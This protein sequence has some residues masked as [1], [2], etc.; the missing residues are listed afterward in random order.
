L[1]QARRID[2]G[3]IKVGNQLDC[4][5]LK[6]GKVS[7]IETAIIKTLIPGE[8]LFACVD[9]LYVDMSLP[10][11]SPLVNY[12]PYLEAA[13]GLSNLRMM[14]VFFDGNAYKWL[15]ISAINS[16]NERHYSRSKN[17]AYQAILSIPGGMGIVVATKSP[18]AEAGSQLSSLLVQGFLRFGIRNH[19]DGA[20]AVINAFLEDKHLQLME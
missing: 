13:I 7:E 3:Y 1:R 10:G 12:Q 4:P 15:H 19:E 2:A 17:W 8:Q 6:G 18:S 16:L 11:A 9:N 5:T 14:I 20:Q